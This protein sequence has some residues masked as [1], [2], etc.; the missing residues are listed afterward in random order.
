MSQPFSKVQ[1]VSLNYYELYIN[2]MKFFIL[3]EH[4]FIRKGCNAK[5]EDLETLSQLLVA[6]LLYNFLKG[7]INVCYIKYFSFIW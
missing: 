1:E 3:C 7:L 6:K 4:L 2:H 5:T